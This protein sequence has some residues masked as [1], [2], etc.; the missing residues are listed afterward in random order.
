[1]E[2]REVSYSEVVDNFSQIKPDL[3]DEWATYFGA[4][5]DD[6][7]VGIVSYVEHQ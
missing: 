2:I 3:L 7:L 1:M 5:V 6:T 4:F